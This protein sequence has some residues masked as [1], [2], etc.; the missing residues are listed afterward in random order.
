MGSS[1]VIKSADVVTLT[2]VYQVEL[3]K[4]LGLKF[5]RGNDGEAYILAS[6]SKLGNTDDR[7]E[8]TGPSLPSQSFFSTI[9]KSIHSASTIW[10]TVGPM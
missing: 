10:D 6:D 3:K 8:V 7:I 4:P 9:A 5:G 1:N 2:F